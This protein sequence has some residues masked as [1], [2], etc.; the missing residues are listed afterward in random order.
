MVKS[1]IKE[2]SDSLSR[3]S[4]EAL[5][6]VSLFCFLENTLFKTKFECFFLEEYL[7]NCFQ[8]STDFTL[9]DIFE[10]SDTVLN[11]MEAQDAED[12]IDVTDPEEV[13]DDKVSEE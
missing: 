3:N 5:V 13:F 2:V 12:D 8:K 4:F 11:L 6:T 10:P 7:L 9:D 1:S